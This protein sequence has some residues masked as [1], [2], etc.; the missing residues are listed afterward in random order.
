MARELDYLSVHVY[1]ASGKLDESLKLLKDFQY[2]KP[3]VIE[4]IFPLGC[5][6]GELEDFIRQSRGSASGWIGFYWGKSPDELRESPQ[7]SDKV[8]LS[9]LELFS[10][11]RGEMIEANR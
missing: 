1:P 11:M 8:L 4:E 10:K 3:V 2:G 5:S 6:I 9:W 7:L